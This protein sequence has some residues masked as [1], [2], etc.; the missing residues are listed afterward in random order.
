MIRSNAHTHCNFCDG[1]ASAEELVRTAIAKGFDAL[2]FSGHSYTPY[3]TSYC[4]TDI[5][6]YVAEIRRLQAKYAGEIALFCGVELDAYGT[7]LFEP[8]YVIGS[9]HCVKHG[10]NY[11]CMDESPQ[12]LEA[13]IAAFGGDEMALVRAYYEQ[14]TAFVC[15]EKP[16]IVGHFDVLTKYNRGHF[17]E[18]SEEYLAIAREAIE[19]ILPCCKLFEVNTGAM[20]RGLKTLP[21]PAPKLLKMLLELGAEV[22]VT[23]DCHDPERLDFAFAQAQELLKEIGFRV[24]VVLK[25]E[26]FVHVPV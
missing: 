15:R 24:M 17:D 20:A 6:A 7:R 2:G 3:D 16:D 14:L 13:A 22:I 25:P 19:N 21:Y 26:G 23:S 12:K 5:P 1:R 4:M 9:L 8:D 11:F 10:G 18:E